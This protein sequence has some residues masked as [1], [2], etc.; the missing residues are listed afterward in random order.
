[1][2]ADRGEG[3]DWLEL[4]GEAALSRAEKFILLESV[5]MSLR[6]ASEAEEEQ[7]WRGED[8]LKLS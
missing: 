1:V 7:G 8:V 5:A 4:V 6:D 2:S 3:V